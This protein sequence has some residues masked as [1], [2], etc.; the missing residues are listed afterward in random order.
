MNSSHA[1]RAVFVTGGAGFVGGRLVAALLEAD[2]AVRVLVRPGSATDLPPDPRV[3]TVR[4]DLL[5]PSSLRA[6]AR[7]GETVFHCAAVVSNLAED[8]ERVHAV[9][10]TG[11]RNLLDAARGVAARFVFLSSI[12]VYGG[13]DLDDL[14]E[15]APLVPDTA[16]GG[17]KIEAEALVRAA[18]PEFAEGA[19]I[20]RPCQ[21]YGPG[22]RRFL[23]FVLELACDRDRL[24]LGDPATVVD[25]VHVDDLVRAACLA[26]EKGGREARAFNITGGAATT[27]GDLL[28]LVGRG[29]GRRIPVRDLEGQDAARWVQAT[30]RRRALR[31]FGR[32]RRPCVAVRLRDHLR[33]RHVGIGRARREL[34]FEPRIGFRDGMEAAIAQVL[35]DRRGWSPV[36]S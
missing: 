16:Y 8:A 15:D 4:G 35:A 26:E 5:D 22:D 20:L 3:E 13:G 33:R 17:S 19:V 11:T 36:A 27:I 21:I 25:F 28:D 18:A 23:P 34:G 30:S 6:C 2:R 14:D 31:S 7:G 29:V 32:I 10:V 24:F 1:D 9:N 12:A